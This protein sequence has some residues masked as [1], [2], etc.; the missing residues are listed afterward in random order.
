MTSI[1]KLRIAGIVEGTTLL[2]LL[3]IAVPLKH[4]GGIPQVVSFV[5]PIHG[6][7]F[8]AYLR[9]LIVAVAEGGWPR[10]DIIRTAIVSFIPLGTFYNDRYLKKMEQNRGISS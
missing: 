1:K 5:G 2:V 4:L 8:L 6:I 9:F 7:A 3:L 10:R